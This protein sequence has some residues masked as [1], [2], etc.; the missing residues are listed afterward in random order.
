[1]ARFD[2]YRTQDGQLV[3]DCQSRWLTHYN[4]RLVVPLM[5]ENA[6]PEIAKRLNP[7]FEIEGA[8]FV[9]VTQ[10][11]AAVPVSELGKKVCSLT[12]HDY[13]IIDA[14]DVL[15]TQT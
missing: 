7:I 13:R 14:I 15:I 3:L 11:A 4:T 12:E 8:L 2:V 10:Y 6:S 1:M 9:M 5:P